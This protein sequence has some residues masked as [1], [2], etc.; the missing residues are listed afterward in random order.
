MKTVVH[1]PNQPRAATWLEIWPLSVV[2][3]LKRQEVPVTHSLRAH[4]TPIQ[5]LTQPGGP[6]QHQI[7]NPAGCA[8]VPTFPLSRLLRWTSA[9]AANFGRGCEMI[10]CIINRK[11]IIETS[12]PQFWTVCIIVMFMYIISQTTSKFR[13]SSVLFDNNYS[14]SRKQKWERINDHK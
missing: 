6:R 9:G 5:P 3:A 12:L 14:F 8:Q 13:K 11:K 10:K 7:R 1:N 4:P 2:C